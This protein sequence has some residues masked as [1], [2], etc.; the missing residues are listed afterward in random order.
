MRVS[1]S[2][3]CV[4]V[5][6]M[7]G[8]V[9]AEAL[10]PKQVSADA[11]WLAHV[12][13]DV[14]RTSV[15]ID[16]GVKERGESAKALIAKIP[17]LSA[18]CAAVDP[19]KNVKSVTAYGTQFKPAAVIIVNA[20]LPESALSAMQEGVG[21]LPDH[22]SSS[23]GSHELHTWTHA[24]GTPHE[25]AVTGVYVEPSII[26]FGSSVDEVKNALDVLDGS[27]PNIVGKSALGA[28]AP[29]GALL[30][31]RVAGLGSIEGLPIN[32]PIIKQA[33]VLGLTMGEDNNEAYLAGEI[34]AK[35]AKTAGQLKEAVDSLLTNALQAID[36]TD[37]G[38]LLNAIQVNAKD[39]SV[40]LD[41]RGPADVGWKYLEKLAMRLG[42]EAQKRMAAQDKK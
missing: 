30:T 16:Q 21:K 22:A 38:E 29:A 12:D 20:N 17:D 23:H 2:L 9:Q 15:V 27:K 40:I 3:V 31:V 42:Q 10:N 6:T 28:A 5:L 26:I 41:L 1:A 32:S 36:D 37:L 35:D 25:H 34:V 18:F 33:D 14:M 13:A 7:A 24:K 19:A 8:F 39:K 11:K 4:L